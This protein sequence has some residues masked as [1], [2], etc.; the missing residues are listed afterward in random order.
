MFKTIMRIFSYLYHLILG[1]FL[2]AVGAIAMFSSNLTLKLDM[3]PWEDPGLTYLIFFGSLA[4]LLSLALALRGALRLPFRIWTVV[5]FALMIYGF[6]MTQY[7]FTGNDHFRNILL[8]TLGALIA[9]IG[10]WTAA[11]KKA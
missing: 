11:P 6:F 2:L 10:S 9:V 8:L 3:L 4:G 7:G 1:L 5:V